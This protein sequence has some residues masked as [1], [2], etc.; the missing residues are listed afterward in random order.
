MDRTCSQ[1]ERKILAR[2]SHLFVVSVGLESYDEKLSVS[3]NVPVMI[4]PSQKI[5]IKIFILL[6]PAVYKATQSH[7]VS[8]SIC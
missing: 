7:R 4:A 2:E 5:M 8:S 1:C 3:L 6:M